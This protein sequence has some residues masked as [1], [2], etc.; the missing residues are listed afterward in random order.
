MCTC[1]S[2]LSKGEKELEKR[3]PGKEGR[4]SSWSYQLIKHTTLCVYILLAWFPKETILV[5][6]P[7][8][9]HT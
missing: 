1:I 3:F 4:L 7:A 5:S 6:Y 8:H 2:L 9:L